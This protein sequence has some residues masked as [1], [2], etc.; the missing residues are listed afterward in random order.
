MLTLLRRSGDLHTKKPLVGSRLAGSNYF[1]LNGYGVEVWPFPPC[2]KFST[3][4]FSDLGQRGE[5][6]KKNKVMNLLKE[7]RE[8][9]EIENKGTT[10]KPR[11]VLKTNT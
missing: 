5:D 6:Q 7:L 4:P 2:G 8:K 11:W 10:H 9:N 3:S 1:S